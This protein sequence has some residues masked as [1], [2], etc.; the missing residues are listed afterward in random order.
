[1]KFFIRNMIGTRSKTEVYALLGKLG[2]HPVSSEYG[3]VEIAEVRFSIARFGALENILQKHGYELVIDRKIILVEKVKH[4]IIELIYHSKALP[5]TNY[6]Q[7][8]STAMGVN[9][10]YL[11]KRFSKVAQTT[12]Q[13]FIISH[14]IERV[15]ELLIYDELTLSEIAWKMEYSSTAHLSAQFKKVTGFTPTAFKKRKNVHLL[16]M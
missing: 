8:L 16:A 11:S 10:T 4:L 3:E 12:I 2:L 15:K 9:Y 13:Q 14:K 1:M 5:R 7:Y 6:S